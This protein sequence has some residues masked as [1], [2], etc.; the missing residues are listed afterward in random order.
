[1][2]R[3]DQRFIPRKKVGGDTGKDTGEGFFETGVIVLS[4]R[5]AGDFRMTGAGRWGKCPG[6]IGKNPHDEGTVSGIPVGE[7]TPSRGRSFEIAKISVKTPGEPI[8]K[9]C[10]LRNRRGIGKDPPIGKLEIHGAGK[11]VHE[12]GVGTI[13]RGEPETGGTIRNPEPPAWEG[14]PSVA[15]GQPPT[16]CR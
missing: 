4:H 15:L 8:N 10:P 6:V 12:K 5:I 16:A 14:S 11:A 13:L 1:M 3:L 7:G 9:M 2:V